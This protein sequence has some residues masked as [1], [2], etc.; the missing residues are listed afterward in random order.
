VKIRTGYEDS[1]AS[2]CVDCEKG[3]KDDEFYTEVNPPGG[4]GRPQ[5]LVCDGC[6]KSGRWDYWISKH[7]PNWP[8]S[9]K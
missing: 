9:R 1:L 8:N 5:V 3:L 7:W 6:M 4:Y 2:A